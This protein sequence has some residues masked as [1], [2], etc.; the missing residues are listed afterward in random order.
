MAGKLGLVYFSRDA[1][2]CTKDACFEIIRTTSEWQSLAT[3][4]KFTELAQ[5]LEIIFPLNDYIFI[6]APMVHGKIYSLLVIR[7]DLRSPVAIVDEVLTLAN[8]SEYH[9]PKGVIHQ[10]LLHEKNYFTLNVHIKCICM[11]LKIA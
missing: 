11:G 8:Y 9:Q 1:K 10:R 7:K 4:V 3:K 2:K 6:E 5:S